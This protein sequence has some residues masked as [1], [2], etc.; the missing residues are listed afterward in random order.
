MEFNFFFLKNHCSNKPGEV[1]LS[2]HPQTLRKSGVLGGPEKP[3]SMERLE[4]PRPPSHPCPEALPP[5]S[6]QCSL[7]KA[8]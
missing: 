5:R 3:L 7:W 2:R 6:R 4:L 1:D 8:R